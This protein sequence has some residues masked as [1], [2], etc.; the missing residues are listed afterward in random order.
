LRSDHSHNKHRG[1][2]RP[3]GAHEGSGHRGGRH[4][5]RGGWGEREEGRG[6]RRRVFD[7]SEL[8]LVLLKLIADEARHGYELIRAVE[9]L[10]GG[11]YVPSPGVV[12]PTLTMLHEMG[13]IEEAESGG[14]RK[15]FSITADGSAE[16]ATH[17]K[18]VDALFARLGELA[19]QRERTD[20]G[21]IRRAMQN[22]RTVLVYRFD[23]DD[24]APDTLHQAAAIL[25]EAAQRIE[26][27]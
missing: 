11:F 25:D 13:Q 3:P 16:L 23:R 2:G 17:K 15:A 4:G 7:S 6:R 20:G 14:A 1:H 12:Y 26:K 10:S 22:L 9:E 8:R 24:V 21:P 27:L 19:S 5:F 18:A